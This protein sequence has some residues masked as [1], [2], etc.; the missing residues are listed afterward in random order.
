MSGGHDLDAV[1]H[2]LETAGLRRADLDPDPVPQFTRWF[3]HARDNGLHQPEAFALATSPPG[4]TPSVRLVLL[5][6]FDARGFVF[7]TNHGSRKGDELAAHAAGGLVF[8]W[9]QLARQ[10]RATG[11]IVPIDAAESDAYFATRP[12]G[13]QLSAWASPQS[14]VV[15]DRQDLDDRRAA[16]EQRWGDR[17]IDRPPFWGGFRLVPDEYEFWQGRLNRYHDRLRY[18]P[19]ESGWVI[20]RLAP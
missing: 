10:V 20:E 8:P 17:E 15:R 3:D 12:R 4:G 9:H 1:R 5:R 18:R 16:Q 13:S 19:V 7:F 11:A 6:G 2:E 14:D